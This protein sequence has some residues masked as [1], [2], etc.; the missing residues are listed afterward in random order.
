[1]NASRPVLLIVDDNR[2]L[3]ENLIDIFEPRGFD[4]RHTPSAREGLSLARDTGF[5]LA[6]VDVNLP[7]ASGA[8]LLPALRATSPAG[9]VVLITGHATLDSAVAAVRGGA[10]HYVVKPFKVDDLVATAEGALR[11]AA[12]RKE[13]ERLAALLE[14]SERRYRGVVESTQVLVVGIDVRGLVR[15]FNRRASEVT[16]WSAD[17]IVGEPMLAKLFTLDARDHVATHV[18][19][20]VSA[21]QRH[22]DE[23]EAPVVTRDG[24]TRTV[25]WHVVAAGDGEPKDPDVPSL[26][27]VGSDVTERRALER[28]AAEAEALAHMGTLAAGLAHEIRN[29]LNAALLQLHLLGRGIDKLPSEERV[30]LPDRVRIVD[31]ELRRLERLLSDFLELARPRPMAR[32][33]IDLERLLDEVLSFQEPAAHAR[34]VTLVRRLSETPAVGDRERLKQVFHNLVVNAMEATPRGGAVT[35]TSLH[36]HNEA[37]VTVADTGRGIPRGTLEKVFE[38]FFTTKEAG[39]GLGLAI[40]RQIVERHGGRVEL[41]SAEL[42]G[43][44]VTVHVPAHRSPRTSP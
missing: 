42:S 12:L 38:P 43:T 31:T 6:L 11:Q 39:T 36:D 24:R 18:A 9:E 14:T 22:G 20:V 40:V 44:R 28:R 35:V 15:F 16:G 17:E 5:D 29:P 34:G 13:R 4:V 25:L 7:D 33:P 23:F 2:D 32:E 37:V 41:E 1:M 21:P 27:A 19:A 10:F 8:E 26:Y 30:N 3:A